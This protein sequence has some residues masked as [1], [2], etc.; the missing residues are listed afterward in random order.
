MPVRPWWAIPKRDVEGLRLQAITLQAMNFLLRFLSGVGAQSPVT[1]LFCLSLREI[2]YLRACFYEEPL[3]KMMAKGL[4]ERETRRGG[5]AL[6][7][8]IQSF[9]LPSHHRL[10]NVFPNAESPGQGVDCCGAERAPREEAWP[11]KSSEPG[12][13]G[14]RAGAGFA[15]VGAHPFPGC[16]PRCQGCKFLLIQRRLCFGVESSQWYL[17]SISVLGSQLSAQRSQKNSAP[18][19]LRAL[20]RNPGPARS[21]RSPYRSYFTRE[22]EH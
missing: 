19:A 13:A 11:A 15:A 3:M 2:S 6:W 5:N 8:A 4:S 7:H 18:S 12:S 22:N 10:N 14:G 21:K 20:V 16:Q 1:S 9:C 17:P